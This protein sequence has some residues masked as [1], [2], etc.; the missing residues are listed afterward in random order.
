MRKARSVLRVL[1]H[2]RCCQ[3]DWLPSHLSCCPLRAPCGRGGGARDLHLVTQLLRIC[4]TV[5]ALAADM[6]TRNAAEAAGR[7]A[8]QPDMASASTGR[9]LRR[10][11]GGLFVAGT[12]AFAAAAMVLSSTFNWPDILREPAGVVL[13]A[14]AGGRHEPR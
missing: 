13:P 6:T 11:T 3:S 8:A 9:G 4:C 1:V 14:F 7:G 10:T 12:V 2:L 5:L